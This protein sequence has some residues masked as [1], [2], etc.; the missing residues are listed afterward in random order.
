MK[1]STLILT[2]LA[3]VLAGSTAAA[4]SFTYTST[5]TEVTQVGGA[6]P[7]GTAGA[8]SI[9]KGKSE[10]VREDGTKTKST[11]TCVSLMQPAD[12][13]IFHIHMSC[14]VD[15]DDGTFTLI[16]G[17]NFYSED[18]TEVGCV[19]GMKGKTGAYENRNGNLSQHS[20][21]GT[22]KGSGQWFD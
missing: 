18:R 8:G 19:G 22:S 5:Q 12:A 15:A 1:K 14:N 13:R 6:G 3:M 4:E 20:K 7:D 9:A 17:C 10:A 21:D 2:T 11:Y 16:A